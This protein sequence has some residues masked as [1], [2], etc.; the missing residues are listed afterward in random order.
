MDAPHAPNTAAP[1]VAPPARHLPRLLAAALDLALAFGLTMVVL[2]FTLPQEYPE[3]L[4]ELTQMIEAAEAD[5]D[6]ASE[7][8]RERIEAASADDPLIRL[9]AYGHSVFLLVH[10]LYF[11]LIAWQGRGSTL[12][13]RICGLRAALIREDD[14]RPS[15][16][17]LGFRGMLKAVCLFWIAPLLWLAFPLIFL[18]RQ[19]RAGY[20]YICGTKLVQDMRKRKRPHG[21]TGEG[22]A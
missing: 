4:R 7:R 12:G 1:A 18:T 16:I 11:W 5:P 19:H 9:L 22:S 6:T 13:Q 15:V 21:A 3:G 20:D 10:W 8:Y 14:E 2:K 17:R